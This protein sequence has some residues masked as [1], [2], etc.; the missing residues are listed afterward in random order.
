MAG[1]DNYILIT[2]LVTAK[3]PPSEKSKRYTPPERVVR[4]CL[5]LL[6]RVKVSDSNLIS[7]TLCS[8]TSELLEKSM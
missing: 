6:K 3:G 1:S 4:M 8:T 7:S 5:T 2:D